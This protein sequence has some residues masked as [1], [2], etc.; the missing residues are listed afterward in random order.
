VGGRLEVKVDTR[1]KIVKTFCNLTARG[2]RFCL[3]N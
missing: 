1:Q 3:T 2:L